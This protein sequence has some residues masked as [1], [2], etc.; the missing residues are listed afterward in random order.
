MGEFSCIF[1]ACA[2]P[3]GENESEEGHRLTVAV[4]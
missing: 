3:F 1:L 4:N 2:A